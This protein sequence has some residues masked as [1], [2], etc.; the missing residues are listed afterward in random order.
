MPGYRR[1]QN[2]L[3][4]LVPFGIL[5]LS[6]QLSPCLQKDLKITM[7]FVTHDQEEAV[8]LADKIAL[9][10]DGVLQQNDTPDKFYEQPATERIARFFG[11]QNF[12]PGTLENGRFTSSIGQFALQQGAIDKGKAILSIR[13]ESIDIGADENSS[14]IV[15][16]KIISHVYMGTHS[17][18]KVKVDEHQFQVVADPQSI[19]KFHDG[20]EVLLRFAP[21]KVWALPG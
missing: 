7:V 5:S 3:V 12:L 20:D 21:D 2:Q 10:F 18:Y 14:N 16:G 6:L 1:F 4:C 8:I 13:P 17:R 11:G 19:R 15:N 9:I